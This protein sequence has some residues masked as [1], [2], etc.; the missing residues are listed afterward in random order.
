MRH[1]VLREVIRKQLKE[2]WHRAIIWICND[3][4]LQACNRLRSKFPLGH[5]TTDYPLF[6]DYLDYVS[7]HQMNGVF[8]EQFENVTGLNLDE[9]VAFAKLHLG[10]LNCDDFAIEDYIYAIETTEEQF[11]VSL[12]NSIAKMTQAPSYSEQKEKC[13]ADVEN[14]EEEYRKLLP[15]PE[16]AVPIPHKC[17][18]CE[19]Y[20]FCS[21]LEG[22]P[23]TQ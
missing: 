14:L 21:T 15:P 4:S 5:P 13:N 23:L 18:I 22:K 11:Y 10:E 8:K 1:V 6:K 16:E 12:F 19:G 17:S 7:T 9:V 3:K 2:V 20:C